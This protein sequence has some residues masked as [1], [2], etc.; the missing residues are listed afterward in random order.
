MQNGV[1]AAAL[2]AA[3]FYDGTPAGATQARDAALDYLNANDFEVP[4]EPTASLTYP[5]ESGGCEV[6]FAFDPA[7]SA[8]PPPAVK[9]CVEVVLRDY[10]VPVTFARA[11]GT[12]L[13]RAGA[14]ANG[15]QRTDVGPGGTPLP[16]LYSHSGTCDDL[17]SM[18]FNGSNITVNGATR[19]IQDGVVPGSNNTFNGEMRVNQELIV[20]G[21]GNVFDGVTY[22]TFLGQGNG[23]VFGP[24][25]PQQQTP[26]PGVYPVNF[27]VDDYMPGGARA[28]AV[29][30]SYR[31]TTSKLDRARL[32][33][34]GALS[35]NVLQPGIYYT[36]NQIDL[37]LAGVTVAGSGG[38]TF[39]SQLQA[40][41]KWNRPGHVAKPFSPND[42]FVFV[43]YRKTSP[44]THKDNCDS[45]ALNL[46]DGVGFSWQGI[47]F[48]PRGQAKVNGQNGTVVTGSIIANA[49]EI[50]GSNFTINAGSPNVTQTETLLLDE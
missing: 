4:A 2:A 18:R 19:G 34:M 39:V 49:F 37:D 6:E 45:S 1:D 7:P 8:S 50:S 46:S 17:K 38:V 35:G 41:M 40:T 12:T 10:E 22:G 16:A 31:S 11:M 20:S 43:N 32:T 33:A 36:S 24:P 21:S 30:S 9:R 3:A 25:P 48:V 42:P 15:C 14:R 26:S 44:T 28:T 23:N 5:C 27:S 13:L 29:G 47:V